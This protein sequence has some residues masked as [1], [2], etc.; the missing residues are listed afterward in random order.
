MSSP[1]QQISNLIPSLPKKDADL[2]KKF[3]DKKD[4]ESLKDLTWSSLQLIEI[5]YEKEQIPDKYKDLDIDKIRE[6]ALVCDEYYSLIYPDQEEIE[7]DFEN[8]EA[9]EEDW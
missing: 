9:V 7:D 2:A 8:F 1:L 5:A 4:W 6:L 3:Y